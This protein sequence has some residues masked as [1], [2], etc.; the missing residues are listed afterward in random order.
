MNTNSSF[1]I[2]IKFKLNKGL[3][4]KKKM[5]ELKPILQHNLPIQLPN[6][7]YKLKNILGTTHDGNLNGIDGDGGVVSQFTSHIQPDITQQIQN[8]LKVLNDSFHN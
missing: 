6:T 5:Y 3:H 7:M 8:I 2:L 4:L 1:D